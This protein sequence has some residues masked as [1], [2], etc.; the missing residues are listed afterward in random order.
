M[1]MRTILEIGLFL[2][3]GATVVSLVVGL[4]HFFKTTKEDREKSNKMM[5]YRIFFQGIALAIF[6]LLLM[7]GR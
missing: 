5:R 4:I 2:A 6:A 7:V 3:M 1:T